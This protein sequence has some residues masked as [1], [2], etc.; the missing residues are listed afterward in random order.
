M[1]HVHLAVNPGDTNA[2]YVAMSTDS[3]LNPTFIYGR[4][5]SLGGLKI[6][7]LGLLTLYDDIGP[8][9]AAS[10]S[11]P[12]ATRWPTTARLPTQIS[13]GGN[14]LGGKARGSDMV[15]S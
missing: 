12:T 14:G 6:S 11:T 15:A 8:L 7:V 3:L 13:A 1:E 4:R 5:G 2:Y 10:T 9:D